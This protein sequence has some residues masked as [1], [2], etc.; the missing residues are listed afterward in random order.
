MINSLY[1]EAVLGIYLQAGGS[2]SLTVTFVDSNNVLV[3]DSITVTFTSAC[4]AGGLANIVEASI[5]TVTGGA[6]ATY[7][8]TG[9]SGSDTITATANVNGTVLTASGSVTVAAATVFA[10]FKAADFALALAIRALRFSAGAISSVI[11]I[12]G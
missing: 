11:S 2:A 4:A 3:G 7:S 5:T 1:P 9:C 8:A 12:N 10:S 6:T